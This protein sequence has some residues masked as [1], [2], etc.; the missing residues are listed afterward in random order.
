MIINLISVDNGVGLTQDMAIV[1]KIL[2]GHACFFHDVKAKYPPRRADINIYFEILNS[3]FYHKARVN[4]FFPNPEWFW[5]NNQLKGI[6]LV[7][8]KTVDAQAIFNRFGCKTIY[9]SFT[10]RD[11]K[12]AVPKLRTYLHLVGQSTNK[13][14][15]EVL[16]AWG[17]DMPEL[18]LCSTKKRWPDTVNV[19]PIYDRLSEQ[20]LTYLMNSTYFHVCPSDYEGFG[21]YIW[22][23]KSC[24]G[25]VITTDG[26][27]MRHFIRDD[28]FLVKIGR[29]SKQQTA[30]LKH[31]SPEDLKAVVKRTQTLSET[32]IKRLSAN[33]R[34]TW[35]D[36]DRF[37]KQIFT[38]IINSFDVK[39]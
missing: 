29:T 17:E 14:T 3:K 28:G 37:F 31:I 4:L 26:E 32:E 13:G 19:N 22:E 10:S 39:D 25:V 5:F 36:N 2:V 16:E 12:V 27:P 1:K 33:A 38:K 20:D 21:H 11:L 23:A 35:I 7:L 24:G 18:I 30:V 34:K 9:T 15:N 6:D 8:C